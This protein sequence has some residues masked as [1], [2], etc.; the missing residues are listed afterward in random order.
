MIH[1]DITRTKNARQRSG[2]TRVTQR[3]LKE[4]GD[5]VQ[6]VTLFA[7]E[8]EARR[9]MAAFNPGKDDWWLTAELFSEAECPGLWQFI[10]DRR[11]RLAAVYN[12]AIPLKSPHQTW[13]QSVARHP[14]YMRMLAEFDHVFAISE[15]SK[16]E[17]LGFWRWQGVRPR[18]VV[19]TLQ[20]GA[21]FS[22]RP[23]A[24]PGRA[25]EG[26]HLLCVGIL[27]P[28]K[29]QA[30]LLDVCERLWS[31]NH[32]FDLHIV[33]RVNPHF[34]KPVAGRIRAMQRKWRC[35]HFHEAAD[36][37]T[38]TQLYAG[39]RASVFPTLAEGCGLPLLE[40]LWMGVPCV[41]SD[42]PVLLE[43]VHGGGCVTVPVNDLARWC[44]AIGRILTDDAH[45]AELSNQACSRELPVWSDSAKVI[46]GR[47]GRG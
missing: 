30:F 27:E 10:H 26:R 3:L 15:T 36:D 37:E 21:D 22:G 17:L 9:R 46:L 5:E 18:A 29:N 41:C 6:T 34:G 47:L 25:G 39:A 32:L 40:S 42:L 44:E 13:P 4:F 16:A 11:C 31:G 7:Q 45:H 8:R 38:M 19:E 14:E 35:L 43:N 24:V 12:D 2:L 1:F 20:L 33:G 23:R 28:R